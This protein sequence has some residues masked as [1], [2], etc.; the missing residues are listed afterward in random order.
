[1]SIVRV[2]PA[3][4][5]KEAITLSVMSSEPKTKKKL[6]IQRDTMRKNIILAFERLLQN[7]PYS[8]I[9]VARICTE[10]HISKPTFYRYFQSK[11]SI[12][13]LLS[14]EAIRCGAAE[15]GRKYT[16]SRGYYRT[17][18]VLERYKA[19]YADPKSPAFQ[20]PINSFCGEYLKLVLFE[21]LTRYK[22]ILLTKKMSFQIESFIQTQS[23][24]LQQWGMK[25]MLSPAETYAEHLASVVPHDLYVALEEP[26]DFI[27]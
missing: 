2:L 5:R 8:E 4:A 21:T 16:W 20:D 7:E 3:V 15:I 18:I 24:L 19:F 27:V 10:A 6:A 11:E 25:D 12:V 17:L 23:Y 1:M 13:W 14:K 22:G 26:T 9:G